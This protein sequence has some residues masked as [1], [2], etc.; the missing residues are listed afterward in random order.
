MSRGVI[1]LT[2]AIPCLVVGQTRPATQ[3]ATR[4]AVSDVQRVADLIDYLNTEHGTLLKAPDWIERS[5]AVLSI[6]KLPGQRATDQIMGV[7]KKDETPFVRLVAWQAMLARAKHLSHADYQAWLDITGAM[8]AKD[9]FRGQSRIGLLRMLAANPPTKAGKTAFVRIFGQT[10]A[11]EP[12][13]MPVLDAMAELLVAWRSPELVEFLYE[14]LNV[15]NDAYRAEY[16][17][18]K[19]GVKAPWAAERLDLGSKAM[20]QLAI[21]NYGQAIRADRATWTQVTDVAPGAWRSLQP[22]YVPAVDLDAP[23]DPDAR[24]WR[25]EMELGKVD[26]R[27]LDVV[28]V[29]DAT[30][31]MGHVHAWLK[32]DIAQIKLAMELISGQPRIGIT[33]YRDHG[34]MFVTRSTKLTDRLNTLDSF[35]GAM[36]ARGGGDRPEAV[37]DALVEA[38]RN[39]P[40]A[41]KRDGRRAVVLLADA[42]PH[43]ATMA[44]CLEI[45]KGCAEHNVHL[46]IAKV[47][48]YLDD[49]SDLVA[50]DE[51]AKAAGTEAF[52]LPEP[53]RTML[54]F[55]PPPRTSGA[56]MHGVR[57]APHP[58]AESAS[59]MILRRLI[60]SAVNPKYA[61][62]IDPIVDL[63]LGVTATTES[64]KREPFGVGSAPVRAGEAVNHAKPRDRQAR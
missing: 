62:R 59:K 34:D 15:L 3:P 10:S 64:E 44:D 51:L 60:A 21:D 19:A 5:L 4:P 49:Q 22:Q 41:W 28:F 17:L 33:F 13:D 24:E 61:D 54:H 39:N 27:P 23:I 45:A 35:I 11:L 29:V 48:D 47:R 38:I 6:A 57:L 52:W 58:P 9:Y 14:R 37:L 7:M 8:A 12:L 53:P 1:L 40:W 46:H 20:W 30:G 25:R 55:N 2:L 63:M 31:S 26:P 32:R 50:L 36:D 43:P 56:G 18:Q 42:P 16:I